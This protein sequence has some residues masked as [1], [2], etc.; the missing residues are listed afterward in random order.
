MG[1]PQ[2]LEYDPKENQN[3]LDVIDLPKGGSFFVNVSISGD[4]VLD[5]YSG[6]SKNEG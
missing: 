5:L 3:V 4:G 1:R 6:A 2:G